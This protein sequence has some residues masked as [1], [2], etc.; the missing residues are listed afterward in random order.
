MESCM[1]EIED[2]MT[3]MTTEYFR[4][5]IKEV[6]MRATRTEASSSAIC[7]DPIDIWVDLPA[8]IQQAQEMTNPPMVEGEVE[9]EVETEVGMEVE[10]HQQEEHQQEEV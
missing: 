3:E 7:T 5:D 1:E 6:R 2:M 10:H 9:V 8:N 4:E